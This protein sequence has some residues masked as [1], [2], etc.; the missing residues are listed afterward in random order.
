[1]G[2]TSKGKRKVT[3]ELDS[4]TI[5]ALERQARLYDGTRGRGSLIDEVVISVLMADAEAAAEVYGFCIRRA[6]E[7]NV[8]ADKSDPVTASR[9]RNRAASFDALRK[10]FST[11]LVDDR[12]D[13]LGESMVDRETNADIGGFRIVRLSGGRREAVPSSISLLNPELEGEA[14]RLWG[15]WAFDVDDPCDLV[16]A[17]E[18]RCVGQLMGFLSDRDDLWKFGQHAPARF[19]DESDAEDCKAQVLE[20]QRLAINALDESGAVGDRTVVLAWAMYD[21]MSTESVI[22]MGTGFPFERGVG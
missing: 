9:L 16:G 3:I 12:A 20:M 15:V 1:M 22:P 5:D 13:L 6:I 4:R 17:S 19:I 14:E 18:G 11:A 2:A 10:V 7:D 8:E 21:M